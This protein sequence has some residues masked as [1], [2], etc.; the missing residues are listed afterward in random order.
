LFLFT[1]QLGP[2]NHG[3]KSVVDNIGPWLQNSLSLEEWHIAIQSRSDDLKG[4]DYDHGI[5]L[6]HIHFICLGYFY[7][8]IGFTQGWL[9]LRDRARSVLWQVLPSCYTRCCHYFKARSCFIPCPPSLGVTTLTTLLQ[10]FFRGFCCHV[11]DGN[12]M[13]R[14]RDFFH[15][16]ILGTVVIW[17]VDF[18]IYRRTHYQLS[19]AASIINTLYQIQL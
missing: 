14:L 17:T 1:R 5:L 10:G 6:H 13:V 2:L 18:R 16:R 12:Y 15:L 11:L 7:S 19:Y 9:D 3:K 4:E 8:F